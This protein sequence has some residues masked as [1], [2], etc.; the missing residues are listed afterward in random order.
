MN[1]TPREQEVA[2]LAWDGLFDKEIAERMGVQKCTVQKHWENIFKRLGIRIEG[3]R[4][5]RQTVFRRL[6]ADG[7]LAKE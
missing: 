6:V 4:A 3:G 2:R 1:L 5:S 7:L